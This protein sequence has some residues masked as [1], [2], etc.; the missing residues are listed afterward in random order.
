MKRDNVAG[1]MVIS[2]EAQNEFDSAPIEIFEDP[3]SVVA[4]GEECI[5]ITDIPA[6]QA[7]KAPDVDP[8]KIYLK[9]IK[10]SKPFDREEEIAVSRAIEE[11]EAL[12]MKT[13]FS[14]LPIAEAVLKEISAS[15]KTKSC[16][17]TDIQQDQNQCDADEKITGNTLNK[18]HIWE[19]ARK[20][21]PILEENRDLVGLLRNRET[22][23]DDEEVKAIRLKLFKN[24]EAIAGLFEG[25]RVEKALLNVTSRIFKEERDRL[26][27]IT[28]KTLFEESG[29]TR[30]EFDRISFLHQKGCT[31]ASTAKDKLIQANL[32]LVVS[33]AKKYSHHGL[34]LAD[35]IQEGN[36]GLIKAVE[37]F[38]YK[39]GYKFSTYAIWWIR[40]AITRAIA[41]QSRTIRVPV[42]MVETMNRVIRKIN[43][44]FQEKGGEP[45]IEDV[46]RHTGLSE[47]KVEMIFQMTRDPISLE[48]PV[49]AGDESHLA[50][51]IED[52]NVQSPDRLALDQSLAEQMRLT[53]STLT[54]K[55][56]KVLRMR[57]GIGEQSDH[58]L[59]EVGKSFMVTRERIRQIEAK[60]IRKLKHPLRNAML[61]VFFE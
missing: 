39:R 46:A 59:E 54:P 52:L 31:E 27:C 9:E 51:F 34:Q 48:T 38:E 21:K 10:D 29:L 1:C 60:A 49:G 18:K 33:I 11:G 56:E 57:F 15:S 23:E 55:E 45:T 36:I 6:V 53:L 50:D 14:I 44:L 20:I 35:L 43:D 16:R 2:K 40:Q 8:L 12:M 25:V 19:I 4:P 30:A 28:D 37:K 17:P 3:E 47:A 32:R 5:S 41:E 22:A 42:H 24:S 13:A 61:K 26:N 7:P 58:T